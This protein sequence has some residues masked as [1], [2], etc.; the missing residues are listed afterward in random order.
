MF[1]PMKIPKLPLIFYYKKIK[2]CKYLCISQDLR[3]FAKRATPEFFSFL[4]KN[5]GILEIS[6]IFNEK[7]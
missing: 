4:I 1:N 3:E 2:N 6:T 7:S 5:V